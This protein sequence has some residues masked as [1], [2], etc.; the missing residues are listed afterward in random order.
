[1]VRRLRR[2]TLKENDRYRLG[3]DIG[4]T[5]TDFT[6]VDV[7]EGATTS[8]KVPTHPA[9]P[10]EGVG[11]G[12]RILADEYG[13]DLGQVEYFVHGM[14]IG[15]N[16]LLQRAG[17]RC[18]LLV[19]EGFRDV[20]GLQRAR[21][22]IP[23]DFNSFL[24]KP[25]IERR[26][27]YGIPERF[28]ASGREV[29]PLDLQAVDAAVD[30][31]VAQ[32]IEAVAVLFLH[33]YRVPDHELAAVRR[34][35]ER[36]P[37]LNVCASSQ[38]WPE[39]REYERAMATVANLYI[40]KNVERY[41]A[42]LKRI[43]VEDGVGI[44]PFIT[45]SNGGIM[46]LD[47]AAASPVKT[48]F[49]GPAA[50]V[51]GAIRE[52]GLA[53]F[54]NLMTFDM[55]GT[56]TDISVVADGAPTY[57]TQ[58]ELGGLPVV[59]PTIDIASVGAGGGSIGWIDASGLLKVGPKSAGS[60][61]GPACYGTSEI[62]ALTDA[63]VLCGYVSPARFGGGRMKLNPSRSL[64]A[65]GKLAD[66]LGKSPLETADDMVRVSVSNMY[67][68]ISNNMEQRGYDPRDLTVVA[69]GGGGP[70]TANIVADEIHARD[71]FVPLHPG[72]LC[73]M[74]S[75]SADFAYD[76]VSAE[77]LAVD[78]AAETTIKAKLAQL[79]DE[80]RAWLDDQRTD[81]IDKDA[82]RVRCFADARYFGQSYEISVPVT[83][84]DGRV[85]SPS[86]IVA[87]FNDLHRHLYGHAEAGAAVEIV[88]L[89]A[90][91]VAATPDLPLADAA[92]ER[93]EGAAQPCGRRAL[94]INGAT[95]DDAAI[96]NREDLRAGDI[97]SGPAVVE[98]DDTTVV[99]IPGWAARVDGRLNLIIER[100][101]KEA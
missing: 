44:T 12:L 60:N 59:L 57:S 74:G 34:I 16:T 91:I 27:V 53:G 37:Q 68:E 1:M 33:S 21:L 13:V 90:R 17:S 80:A 39:M 11:E 95:Y 94:R 35:Q 93:T 62:P 84:E 67:A 43:L 71:V 6:L 56:S 20:L 26:F 89:R 85:M 28:D 96:Y 40:Q 69:Y 65:I 24:P 15:L 2:F 63:F 49:S 78:D 55:G 97:I 47:S 52:A 46:N 58:S 54:G 19:T 98:Q 79:V 22:P 36:Y 100:V 32:G 88:N 76:A 48:L 87:A 45:Q 8:L 81:I 77:Q 73:A 51:I 14:T 83:D 4:G 86:Q 99:V 82:A 9:A 101:Q 5:F 29:A 75:L 70:V 10:E 61:P 31:A 38:V 42:N 3:V 66:Q 18:A 25:L 64:S 23:Y 72:T 7:Q 41:F 50:G 92:A 30:D